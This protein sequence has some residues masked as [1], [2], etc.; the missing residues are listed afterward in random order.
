MV[1]ELGGEDGKTSRRK[2]GWRLVGRVAV[3]KY[4]P[5]TL[6]VGRVRQ[7]RP[8]TPTRSPIADGSEV[9]ED[10]RCRIPIPS[11]RHF[12]HARLHFDTS[13]VKNLDLGQE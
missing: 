1:D 3:A 9:V 11:P 12:I 13:Q 6:Y 7:V 8:P 2:R 10:I 4:M 5:C